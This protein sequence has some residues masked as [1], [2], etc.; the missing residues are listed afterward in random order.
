MHVFDPAEA[1]LQGGGKNDDGHLRPP[2]AQD[3]GH[4]R[5]E[6]ARAQVVVEHSDINLV[7]QLLRLADGARSVG[8]VTMLA[9]DGGSK[10]QILWI[11]V[12]QQYADR[13]FDQMQNLPSVSPIGWFCRH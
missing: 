8:Q 4:L 5:T 6:L 13:I 9:Q 11:I 7:E 3:A 12:K 2:P 1:P 10:E